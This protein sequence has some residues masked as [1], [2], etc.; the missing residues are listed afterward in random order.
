MVFVVWLDISDLCLFHLIVLLNSVISSSKSLSSFSA[1]KVTTGT[2]NLQLVILKTAFVGLLIPATT[3]SASRS[4]YLVA[5]LVITQFSDQFKVKDTSQLT[6]RMFNDPKRLDKN[7]NGTT[8]S[9]SSF[10]ALLPS[11]FPVLLVL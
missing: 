2:Y 5:L 10:P 9:I 6:N 3:G 1:D 4:A 8:I 11:S 7:F